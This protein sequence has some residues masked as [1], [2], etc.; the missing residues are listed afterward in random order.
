MHLH[1]VF[2]TTYRREVFSKEIFDDLR[3]MLVSV[4]TDFDAELVKFDGE[5]DQGHLLMNYPSKVSVSNLV[6]SLK[7]V[8]S[9][10]IR[11][12]D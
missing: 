11:K 7:P 9:R 5:D 1:F 4:C 8:S 6:N 12:K 3:P 10:R 2:V